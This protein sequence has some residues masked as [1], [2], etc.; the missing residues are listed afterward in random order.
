MHPGS[1]CDV[2]VAWKCPFDGEIAVRAKIAHI[3]PTGGDGVTWS[4]AHETSGKSSALAAGVLDNGGSQTVA[5][6]AK[7]TEI[8]VRKDDRILLIVGRRGG[9][10]CDSTAV[11][12]V[13]TQSGGKGAAGT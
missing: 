4:I 13:I 12:F 9:H 11:E 7:L 5:D 10:Q 6:A 1:D 8:A 2:A 3:Q